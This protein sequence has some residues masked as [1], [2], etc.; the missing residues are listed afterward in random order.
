MTS[1]IKFYNISMEY[2]QSML[3][4]ELRAQAKEC[5]DDFI[6]IFEQMINKGIFGN[7]LNSFAEDGT[8]KIIQWINIC[9]SR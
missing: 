5:G 4:R 8:N 2:S 9:R 6:A 7:I 1:C 3:F